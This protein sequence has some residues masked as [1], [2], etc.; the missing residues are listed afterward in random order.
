MSV[1]VYQD[2]RNNNGLLIRAL[3]RHFGPQDIGFCDAQDIIDGALTPATRLLVMPG[4]ADLYYVEKLN[5]AGNAAIRA[6]VEAGG[7]YLGIC[8]G[9][10]YASRMVK[11]AEDEGRQAICGPRELALFKGTARG[12]VYEFIEDGDF[13]KSW[14]AAVMITHG[15]GRTLVPYH[16]GPVFENVPEGAMVIARYADLPDQP[17][18]IVECAIGKGKAVLCGPHLEWDGEGLARRLYEHDNPH[19]QWESDVLA[20]LRG[21][22]RET[23][24]LWADMMERCAPSLKRQGAAA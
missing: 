4:G 6:W 14:H 21:S 2:Y 18:A 19:W 17:A 9:A 23:M 1:L 5:G 16:A 8:A 3:S 12:P 15:K 24:A 10:Y 11:W 22:E 7:A 13:A 20:Q